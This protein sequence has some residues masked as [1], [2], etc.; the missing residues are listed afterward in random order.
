MGFWMGR[1]AV[2][3]AACFGLTGCSA[4]SAQQEISG[5]VTLDGQQVLDGHLRFEPVDGKTSSAEAFVKD[6]QYT[7]KLTPGRY[8]VEIYSPR[9]KGKMVNRVPGPGEKVEVVEETIPARYNTNT[10]LKVDV[11]KGK[12]DG[13]DFPLKSQ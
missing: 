9:S 3:M 7:A 4:G 11:E 5:A 13:Y 8:K 12:K 2:L 1:A 6:G 10:Q